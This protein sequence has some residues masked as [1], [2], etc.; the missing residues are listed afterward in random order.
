[1]QVLSILDGIITKVANNLKYNI[2][3]KIY[4]LFIYFATDWKFI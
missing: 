4:N 2:S 3:Y 1:M